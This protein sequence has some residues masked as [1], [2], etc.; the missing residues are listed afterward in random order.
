MARAGPGG[1]PPR[2]SG[3]TKLPKTSNSSHWEADSARLCWFAGFRY[4]DSL[5]EGA[6]RLPDK[7]KVLVSDN[8]VEMGFRGKA[9]CSQ[10]GDCRKGH[11]LGVKIAPG[12]PD[13]GPCDAAR[14]ALRERSG[15]NEAFCG[16]FAQPD[17]HYDVWPAHGKPGYSHLVLPRAQQGTV[18][19]HSE[20]HQQM[21]GRPA[22]RTGRCKSKGQR[23]LPCCCAAEC[24]SPHAESWLRGCMAAAE[25][26]LAAQQRASHR[27]CLQPTLF[28][29]VPAC[30]HVGWMDKDAMPWPATPC[31]LCYPCPASH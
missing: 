2:A 11:K 8:A 3:A 19:I 25:A 21:D 20:Q 9:H 22:F 27:G 24:C 18:G 14:K 17:C 1:S 13:L 10:A 6:P 4:P 5:V 28:K 23:R 15:S 30:G 7:P 31:T 16:A 12:K 29:R 26:R